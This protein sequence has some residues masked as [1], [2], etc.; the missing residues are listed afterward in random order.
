MKLL[1]K[2]LLTTLFSLAAAGCG[3]AASE[4]LP[5]PLLNEGTS[6]VQQQLSF[7]EEYGKF[8]FENATFGG[9]GRTCDTCHTSSTG[10]LS[11]AQAQA[12]YNAN[13]ND[14][15]FRAI[16]SDDGTGASYSKLL[17]HATVTVNINLPSN[18]RLAGS[19]ARSVTLRRAI[20]STIDTPKLD[21]M[22]MFDGRVTTLQNQALGAIQGHAQTTYTPS[23]YS[24]DSIAAYEKTLFSSNAM[25]DYAK[26]QGPMP[27][28]PAG[29][30]ASEQRGAAFFAPTGLCGSC[31]GGP[32]LNTNQPGNPLG[33]PAGTQFGT[34]L[35]SEANRLNNP[36]QTYLVRNAQGVEESI[37]TADPGMMLVTGNKGDANL[38]KMLSLRNLKNTAPYFHDG[39]AK[40][41]EEIMVQYDFVLN[42]FG[43]PHTQQDIADM[44][45]YLYLL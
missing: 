40:T 10:S 31:H 5:T 1:P 11:P 28:I 33:L 41:I 32:L 43:I 15:L 6:D 34:S 35:A 23:Q 2:A 3:D 42:A 13:P 44:T 38:F 12:R 30:T 17:T 37:T 22:L 16:D 18:I 24:L 19:S 36:V 29:T 20:P 4:D 21:T 27:G 7:Q 14:P 45:A 26:G 25:R 9:N 39:S 8:L